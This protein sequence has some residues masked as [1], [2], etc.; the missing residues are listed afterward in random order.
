VVMMVV[1]ITTSCRSFCPTVAYGPF[2]VPASMAPFVSHHT[3][4]DSHKP[5]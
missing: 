2:S 1:V 4:V 3:L 5:H